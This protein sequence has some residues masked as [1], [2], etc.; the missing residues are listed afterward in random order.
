M[1]AKELMI[2]DWVH[3]NPIS[4]KVEPHDSRVQSIRR[5]YE[6]GYVYVEGNYR[7]EL[8]TDDDFND[9]WYGWSVSPS[10]LSPI[11]LTP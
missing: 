2:G 6:N 3:V 8:L 10:D 9:H 7:N 5:E 4:N 11:P 1:N